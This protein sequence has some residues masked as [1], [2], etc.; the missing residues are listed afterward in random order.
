MRHKKVSHDGEKRQKSVDLIV[1]TNH[2]Y[3]EQT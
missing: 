2:C 1:K 3:G